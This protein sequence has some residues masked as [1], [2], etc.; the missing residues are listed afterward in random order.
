MYRSHFALRRDSGNM[1]AMVLLVA[2]A[3]FLVLA[4][5]LVV[6]LMFFAERRAQNEADAI[7][8][9]MAES[10]ND[11]DCAGRMNNM[12]ARCRELVYVSRQNY[13]IANANYKHLLPLAQQLLEESRSSAVLLESERKR[14]LS[15]N[16]QRIDQSVQQVESRFRSSTA[17]TLP[18]LTSYAPRIVSVDLGTITDVLSNI[19]VSDGNPS[20]KERDLKHGYIDKQSG[21][22]Y[23]NINAKL[24]PPDND[25]KFK[26]CSLPP[27]VQGSIAPPRLT[28]AAVFKNTSMS[29]DNGSPGSD[30]GDQL[31]SAVQVG[32]L[33]KIA[34]G[35]ISKSGK[36]DEHDIA[37]TATAAAGGGTPMP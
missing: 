13:R 26:F 31:P 30:A 9:T 6:Y 3:L 16:C 15:I 17:M 28:S 27:A 8:L 7:S 24:P 11:N 25:L 33:M 1:F 5:G 18:G 22:Y 4:F 12:I 2:A 10:L 37:V 34:T 14:L 19:E 29:G 35:S 32:L 21:L 36:A 20:L 23:G